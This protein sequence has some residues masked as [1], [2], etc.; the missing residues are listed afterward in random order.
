MQASYHNEEKRPGKKWCKGIIKKGAVLMGGGKIVGKTNC[1]LEKNREWE[2]LKDGK[3]T[4]YAG[5]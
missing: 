5:E 3:N 2:K 4:G 1:V